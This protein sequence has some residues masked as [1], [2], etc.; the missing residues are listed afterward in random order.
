MENLTHC[1][2]NESQVD[3]LTHLCNRRGFRGILEREVS[4]AARTGQPLM[5][6]RIDVSFQDSM[7]QRKNEVLKQLGESLAACIRGVDT[8]SRI[9]TQQ[10]ILLTSGSTD[11]DHAALHRR[12]EQAADRIRSDSDDTTFAIHLSSTAVPLES[13]ADGDRILECTLSCLESRQSSL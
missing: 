11:G 13:A 12:I 2:A 3:D 4:R 8:L 5:L 10:F 6:C 9:D 7:N 1:L